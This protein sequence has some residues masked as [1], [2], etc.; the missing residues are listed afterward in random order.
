MAT[1][2][3][4]YM[5]FFKHCSRAYPALALFFALSTVFTA[6]APPR[7]YLPTERPK[8]L[9]DSGKSP[10][11]PD[12]SPVEIHFFFSRTFSMRGFLKERSKTSYQH[13]M[14]M[15]TG[16]AER[17][18]SIHN[19]QYNYYDYGDDNIR[20]R[21]DE[22]I[23]RDPGVHSL[24]FYYRY[25]GEPAPHIPEH[26][27]FA[28][29]NRRIHNELIKDQSKKLFVVV[30]NFYE[31]NGPVLFS[32]FFEQ[33][34]EQGMSGAIFA[35]ESEFNGMIYNV[36]DPEGGWRRPFSTKGEV[37]STFFIFI[38]GSTAEV[39]SYCKSL[40]NQLI[41]A[42]SITFKHTVFLLN[43]TGFLDRIS[44]PRTDMRA[45]TGKMAGIFQWDGTKEMPAA[46][47]EA[48]QLLRQMKQTGPLYSILF[49]YENIFYNNASFEFGGGLTTGYS[50]G[51]RGS[52]TPGFESQF[53]GEGGGS[54]ELKV[55]PDDQ[56]GRLRVTVDTKDHSNLSP[57]FYRLTYNIWA[58]FKIP[59]WVVNKN[60]LDVPSLNEGTLKVVK[61]RDVYES[62][63]AA[64]NKYASL[65]EQTGTLYLVK[66]N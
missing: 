18:W 54:F 26:Q 63:L 32:R 29:V 58:K 15:I 44:R 55:Q 27:P 49:K 47:V 36:L 37:I 38:I 21:T 14:P 52:V 35:V 10:V 62:I 22:N 59:D 23:R 16:A 2:K 66:L 30:N 43:H 13:T 33:A 45:V 6:C 28:S 9:A 25:G 4:P 24:D 12:D 56:S 50:A 8:S 53:R 34:F 61:L 57:G 7:V 5:I 48:Y 19:H 51:E 17:N 31:T 1:L 46:G 42:E 65:P 39:E 11:D 40:Y 64:Y 60:T 41:E 3:V 20:S